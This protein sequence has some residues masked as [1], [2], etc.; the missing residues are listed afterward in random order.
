MSDDS[1]RRVLFFPV[2]QQAVDARVLV[3]IWFD[4]MVYPMNMQ[5]Y[6][7]D[8]PNC[9]GHAEKDTQPIVQDWSPGTQPM[10]SHLHM[11]R[12][13]TEWSFCSYIRS[14]G[15]SDLVDPEVGLGH[16]G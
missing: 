6:E 7:P 9:K 13:Q 3:L 5:N 14:G 16:L 11:C 15:L 12:E 10:R 4:Q 1:Q 2:D 8:S